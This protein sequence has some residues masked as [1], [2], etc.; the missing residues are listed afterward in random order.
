MTPAL[1]I[2]DFVDVFHYAACIKG[3]VSWRRQPVTHK[4]ARY[5]ML[6]ADAKG[7]DAF[8]VFMGIVDLVVRYKR[9][10]G[11]LLDAENRPITPELVS[12][13]T[14][15]PVKVCR[16][17]F[18]KLKSKD[19]GWLLND[20]PS[21]DGPSTD[22]RLEV[23]PDQNRSERIREEGIELN[24]SAHAGEASPIRIELVRAGVSDEQA[25]VILTHPKFE[26][27]RVRFVLAQMRASRTPIKHPHRYVLTQAGM[28]LGAKTK[29][30]SR[31]SEIRNQLR[32]AG[33][34]A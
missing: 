17:G 4:S 3:E 16:E 18:E 8:A 30:A 9:T 14:G 1:Y 6:M 26:E 12:V 10:D 20:R 24:K 2:K 13:S 27:Q 28:E 11:A 25:D 22:G 34:G 5:R 15:I 21:I 32:I 29:H 19:I 7:R 33:G 23:D 31:M